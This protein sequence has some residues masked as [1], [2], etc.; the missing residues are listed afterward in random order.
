MR[1]A[2]VYSLFFHPGEVTEI[3]AFGLSGKNKGWE[4]W[5]RGAGIVYGYFDNA[6]A[7]GRSAEAL[8]LA[9]APG[10]YF[11]LNPVIP[12]LLAR[13]AN[14]LRAADQ[15][16]VA[17]SD[18]DVKVLRW[19]YVDL[20][21]KRPT[22]ISST[23]VELQAAV[24][25]RDKINAYLKEKG[26]KGGIPAIS[27]NGAHLL[28]QIRDHELTNRT[29]PSQDPTVI[30]IRNV[31]KHLADKFDSDRVEVDQKT[32][33]PSRICKLYGTTAR[34]GD[35]TPTRPYRESYIEPDFLKG[36]K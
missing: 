4:G 29:E 25:T 36:G 1:C 33:N 5:A 9:K 3:R 34:K 16:T 11:V 28:I 21:P 30:S 32:F 6:E 15:K 26:F 8:E 27:G 12:D 35:H 24:E 2:D 22:G 18:K 20:D 14:R 31:L 19:I 7:F 10:I 17:T 23:A 13:A